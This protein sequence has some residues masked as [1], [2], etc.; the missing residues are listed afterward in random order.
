MR[1]VLGMTFAALLLAGRASTEP[2]PTTAA[3]TDLLTQFLAGA[4]RND[5]AVHE[6]FWA[7]ELVYT[8]S[9]GRRIGKADIL[10][11]LSAEASPDEPKT[12]YTAEDVR[13]QDLGDLAV[14]TFRLVGATEQDGKTFVTRY[15]NTGT[16]RRKGGEWRAVAWQATRA[17]LDEEQ[18]K[19]DLLALENTWNAA[20]VRGDAD[21]LDRL[22]A[23]DLVVS[24]PRM[25][26][27]T[28]VDALSIWR[29]GR[30]RFDRYETSDVHVALHG[31]S[32]VV[33]GRLV[34]SRIRDGKA[35][36][37]DYRFT[38][39]YMRTATGWKV[40]AFHASES[41]AEAG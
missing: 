20:H 40:V 36:T 4:S 19:V 25:P 34:R 14:V 11:D 13:I 22:W 24:V 38:K 21:A 12:T 32:A 10:R 41:P 23:E 27:M 39:T 5:R 17:A 8:G 37:D 18:A 3:L 7:D 31:E 16:F 6:R 29:S 30:M 2:T 1:R 33:T 15:L 35:V 26:S 9:A 28:K